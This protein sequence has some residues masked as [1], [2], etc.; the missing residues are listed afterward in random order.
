MHDNTITWWVLYRYTALANHLDGYPEGTH[1][2]GAVTESAKL[3]EPSI[4]RLL[5]DLTTGSEPCAF[6][7][8]RRLTACPGMKI[9][10]T[11]ERDRAETEAADLL[12]TATVELPGNMDWHTAM[13]TIKRKILA[14]DVISQQ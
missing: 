6:C 2:R 10:V 12:H 7:F 13:Q 4:V 1:A 3:W 5:A 9:H 8:E 14:R 11:M